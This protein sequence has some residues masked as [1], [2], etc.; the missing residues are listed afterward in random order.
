M[1]IVLNQNPVSHSLLSRLNI[2]LQRFS[3]PK[4]T[5]LKNISETKQRVYF[6]NREN[7]VNI[8]NFLHFRNILKYIL[9]YVMIW[10]EIYVL[11][12]LIYSIFFLLFYFYFLFL[13]FFVLNLGKG[14][15]GGMTSITGS[16]ICHSH[17]SHN[18]I[19]QRKL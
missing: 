3:R 5:K 19:I 7:S 12:V 18:H 13:L 17:K 1:L 11:T 14:C 8:W 15:D 9:I 10:L 4:L 16:Y 6:E 2:L